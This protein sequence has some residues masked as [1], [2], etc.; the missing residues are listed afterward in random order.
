M[1]HLQRAL[2]SPEHLRERKQKAS[3]DCEQK[4]LEQKKKNKTINWKR[5]SN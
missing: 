5:K 3:Q 4:S 1:D 2:H